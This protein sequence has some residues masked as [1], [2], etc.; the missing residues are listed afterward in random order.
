MLLPQLLVKLTDLE[1]HQLLELPQLPVKLVQ[2]H[3]LR[4]VM[5]P[6]PLTLNVLMDLIYQEAPVLPVQMLLLLLHVLVLEL[7]LLV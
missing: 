1:Y 4:N 7:L 5:P 2:T 3:L 6:L